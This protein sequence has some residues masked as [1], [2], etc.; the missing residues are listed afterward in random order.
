M[1]ISTVYNPID[2]ESGR[3]WNLQI[4]LNC[5]GMQGTLP[6]SFMKCPKN[7]MVSFSAEIAVNT[8]IF[9]MFSSS[10]SPVHLNVKLLYLLVEQDDCGLLK[11]TL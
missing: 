2:E 1:T 6:S 7:R 9:L 10:L 5:K 11:F 4:Q 8:S 3:E